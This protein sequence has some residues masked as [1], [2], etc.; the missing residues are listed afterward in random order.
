MKKTR[1]QKSHAS[2]PLSQHISPYFAI[3]QQMS[4]W[5]K[6]RC[7]PRFWGQ[8]KKLHILRLSGVPCASFDGPLHEWAHSHPHPP[9]PTNHRLSTQEREEYSNIGRAIFQHWRLNIPMKI[10]FFQHF[11]CKNVRNNLLD[12]YT[13]MA[14]LDHVM[15]YV[16]GWTW[17]SNSGWWYTYSDIEWAFS[18]ILQH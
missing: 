17:I 16:G 18:D 13:N 2:V 8:R 15:S 10:D 6:P 9:P 11:M 14:A 7:Q 3:Y 12:K 5:W 1:A 4:I